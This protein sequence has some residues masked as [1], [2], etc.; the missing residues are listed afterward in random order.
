MD[1]DPMDNS[2]LEETEAVAE[3]QAVAEDYEDDKEEPEDDESGDKDDNEEDSE[4]KV[5]EGSNSTK[6]SIPIAE[7]NGS[8]ATEPK[9]GAAAAS[10]S[11]SI[12]IPVLIHPSSLIPLRLPEM[13]ASLPPF[14]LCPDLPPSPPLL[15]LNPAQRNPDCHCHHR[16]PPLLP[17]C[18]PPSG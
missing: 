12:A 2:Q 14:L 11:R 17:C 4:S 5:E 18:S 10:T 16:R 8:L 9:D 1:P 3:L 6:N 7:L 13:L 15:Q